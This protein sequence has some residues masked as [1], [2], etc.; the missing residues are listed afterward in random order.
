MQL[1][2]PQYSRTRSRQIR[3]LIP[4][5]HAEVNDVSERGLLRIIAMLRAA[6]LS[7]TRRGRAGHWS[8][9]ISRHMGLQEALHA[10][11]RALRTICATAAV[12]VSAPALQLAA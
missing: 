8:Y 2:T 9:E 7:E 1:Y 5:T 3:S 11:R 10:E 12:T 6:N 4:V